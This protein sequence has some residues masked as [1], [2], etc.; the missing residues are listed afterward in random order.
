M[1][2]TDLPGV[3]I[4]GGGLAGLALSIQLCS[5]GH[6]VTLFEKEKYPFHKVC[7]EYISLESWDFLKSL[8][9]PLDAMNLPKV[10]KLV[11]SSL[12]GTRLEQQLPLGGFG[13]SRYY[14]DN[15]LRKIAVEKGVSVHDQTK[16]A[17][18]SFADEQFV[19]KTSSGSYS[20]KVCCG[21]YG[22]RSNID[23]K[24]NRAFTKDRNPLLNNFVAVKYHIRMTLDPGTIALHNFRNGY[25]GISAIEEDKCCLCYLTTAA[26]LRVSNNSIT[27]MEK[28]VLSKNKY[29]DHIFRNSQ[30]LYDEP[31]T[32][33]QIS[34]SKKSQV[35][36]HVLMLGDAAGMITPLCGNGMS[37]ALHSSKIAAGLVGD[38]LEGRIDRGGME[39]QYQLQWRKNFAARLATGR[40][41]QKMFGKEWVTN[42]F[43]GM[44]KKMP[45]LTS[46]LIRQTHGKPF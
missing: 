22:K 17:A 38:F 23:I 18:V 4:I 16:V 36:E 12:N 2:D 44:M 45:A 11:V 37:M 26:N 7:G 1:S 8:G 43:I 25:G 14:L 28:Q 9:L 34:F 42:Q 19:L 32:I 29:L 3:C 31:L 46:A 5:Q 30:M 40:L 21:S 24:L 10:K 15:E 6:P 41:V 20:G 39:Q 27:Q 35:E 13:I 33:S